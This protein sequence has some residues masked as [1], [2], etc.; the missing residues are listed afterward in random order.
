[1]AFFNVKDAHRYNF[2]QI[3]NAG[4]LN[5]ADFV[6]SC[7]GWHHRRRQELSIA[8]R[9]KMKVQDDRIVH[10]QAHEYT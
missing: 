2:S 10:G 7:G 4:C 8:Y 1:M 3:F 9:R 5:D 6:D